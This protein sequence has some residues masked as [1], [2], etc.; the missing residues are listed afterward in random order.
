MPNV[1]SLQQA[2]KSIDLFAGMRRLQVH[3]LRGGFSNRTYLVLHQ[4]S[5]FV[6]RID[7]DT[8]NLFARDRAGEFK[9]QQALAKYALAP[10]PLFQ[11]ISTGVTV[12]EFIEGRVLDK[13][14][15]ITTE[16]LRQLSDY[17]THLHAFRT[18]VA[19]TDF[20]TLARHFRSQL[21]A[22]K[23]PW[24][25]SLH[26]H[27]RTVCIDLAWLQ[28]SPASL[29]FCHNDLTPGNLII[30]PTGQLLALDW[31][32]S[33][34]NHPLFDLAILSINWSLNEAQ[35]A[36]AATQFELDIMKFFPCA[37]RAALLM[38]ALWYALRSQGDQNALWQV[39]LEERLQQLDGAKTSARS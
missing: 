15:L 4:D 31:E 12:T 20:V 14:T 28:K 13:R 1:I 30:T 6:L 21:S 27:F 29:R 32:Y 17:R 2:L 11:D 36:Q 3:P 24:F 8:A 37:R 33:G 34:P 18:S 10:Q 7:S 19:A 23:Q 9:L 26:R 38:E 25:A 39:M 35:I 22:S 5:K 16:L